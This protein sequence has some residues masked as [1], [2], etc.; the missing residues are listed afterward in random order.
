[1]L[2]LNGFE[3]CQDSI[4]QH[5][6][7][8]NSRIIIFFLNQNYCQIAMIIN[9]MLL[10]DEFFLWFFSE[11]EAMLRMLPVVNEQQS[12]T[13][14]YE[15]RFENDGQPLLELG[16]IPK[17]TIPTWAR[18]IQPHYPIRLDQS[19]SKVNQR[20]PGDTFRLICFYYNFLSNYND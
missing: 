5:F 12:E 4:I 20:F 13:T 14:Q 8:S 6:Q 7:A 11:E 10:F 9:L 19:Y 17:V 18:I 16:C 3:I 2:N 15:M 1:M